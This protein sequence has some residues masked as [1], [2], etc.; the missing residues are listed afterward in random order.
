MD[1]PEPEI[2]PLGLRKRWTEFGELSRKCWLKAKA[3]ELPTPKTFEEFWSCMKEG[4]PVVSKAEI[5]ECARI[6][7]PLAPHPICVLAKSAAGL[8][9]AEAVK[10]CLEE[11]RVH[12]ISRIGCEAA[13]RGELF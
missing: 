3:K 8:T 6:G 1:S 7:H 11:G 10:Q 13:R 2:I 12:G 9:G 4:D 5:E